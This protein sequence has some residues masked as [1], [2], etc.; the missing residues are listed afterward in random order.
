MNIATVR[1]TMLPSLRRVIETSASSAVVL[2]RVLVGWVFVSE[3]I[4]KFLF[5]DTVGA[6]R[7]Q[8]IGIPAPEVAGPFVGVIEIVCGVLILLGLLT[9]IAAVP[10]LVS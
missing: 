2:I 3:G 7:F 1:K 10:L 8:K 4:Q 9:R 5:A 6:G